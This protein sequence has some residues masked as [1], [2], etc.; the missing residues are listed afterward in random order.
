MQQ[1]RTRA[2]LVCPFVVAQTDYYC[3]Q[4]CLYF[5]AQFF[6]VLFVF[7]VIELG[8]KIIWGYYFRRRGIKKRVVFWDELFYRVMQKRVLCFEKLNFDTKFL[9]FTTDFIHYLKFKVWDF[10]LYSVSQKFWYNL[11]Q[12]SSLM[13]N[14]IQKLLRHV[15]YKFC[16]KTQKFRVILALIKF[17]KCI[18]TCIFLLI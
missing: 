1:M 15:V 2:F 17:L 3:S 7:W 18:K 11:T 10:I 6:D 8:W 5:K 13:R 12:D 4:D 9:C 14:V 16:C